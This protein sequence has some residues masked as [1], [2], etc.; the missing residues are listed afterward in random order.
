MEKSFLRSNDGH[1][2]LPQKREAY[3]PNGGGARETTMVN[4]FGKSS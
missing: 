3:A 2:H 1:C 4:K